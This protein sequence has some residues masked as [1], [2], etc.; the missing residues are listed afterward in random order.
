V[1]RISALSLPS[2]LPPLFTRV[3]I[4]RSPS[5]R[6]RGCLRVLMSRLRE[7]LY[8]FRMKSSGGGMYCDSYMSR[9]RSSGGG[10]FYCLGFICF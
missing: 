8:V 7:D 10:V 9:N 2:S 5:V 1:F 3:H 6:R 4:L